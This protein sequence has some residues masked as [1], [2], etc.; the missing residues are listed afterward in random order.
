MRSGVEKIS[1]GSR[2]KVTVTGNRRRRQNANVVSGTDFISSMPVRE[3]VRKMDRRTP[4]EGTGGGGKARLQ[5]L[6]D[7][8]VDNKQKEL[9]QDNWIYIHDP[10]VRVGRIQNFK[11]WS[12]SMVPGHKQNVPRVL[13]I[14]VSKATAF[15]Q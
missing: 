15:G 1:F 7:C 4:C 14:S 6:F 2:G 10:E 5:R 12:P 11:N 13:N 9:F 8:F 3:L